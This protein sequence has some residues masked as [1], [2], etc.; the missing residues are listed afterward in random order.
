MTDRIIPIL[1]ELKEEIRAGGDAEKLIPE[2]AAEYEIREDVLRARFARAFP[3][4]V[5]VAPPSAEEMERR[6]R[7]HRDAEN[8]RAFE[9]MQAIVEF[10]AARPDLKLAVRQNIYRYTGKQSCNMATAKAIADRLTK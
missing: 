5:P 6:R 8:R 2:F 3:N 1:D 9:E 7:E 4:G 10:F